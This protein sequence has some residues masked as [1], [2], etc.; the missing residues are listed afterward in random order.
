MQVNKGFPGGDPFAWTARNT[1]LVGAELA[2]GL[3]DAATTRVPQ[4]N[5][6][7]RRPA[8][9]ADDEISSVQVAPC[10]VSTCRAFVPR[11]TILERLRLACVEWACHANILRSHCS[12]LCRNVESPLDA[13]SC[14][15]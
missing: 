15:S 10:L 1:L 3:L 5:A 11:S 2:N 12:P 7:V 14:V 9:F 13:R 6:R 8:I 4:S